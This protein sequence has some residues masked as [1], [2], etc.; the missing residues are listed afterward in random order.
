MLGAMLNCWLA[1]ALSA[2]SPPG[3]AGVVT[4]VAQTPAPAPTIAELPQILAT[5]RAPGARAVLVNVWATWC[6]RCRE[7]MPD[8]IR[9]FRD[10]AFER[11]PR[12]AAV[13]AGRGRSIVWGRPRASRSR[14]DRVALD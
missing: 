7:E 5:A 6:D 1:F 9:F 12:V 11:S 10:Q 13:T 4:T 3:P 8:L 2:V 14:A